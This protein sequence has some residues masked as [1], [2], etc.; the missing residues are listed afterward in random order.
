MISTCASHLPVAV[1]AAWDDLTL[2]D[3]EAMRKFYSRCHATG[4]R[5]I[6]VVDARRCNA[7]AAP[8]RR[9]L[10]DMTNAFEP[11]VRGRSIGT[12][13]ILDSAVLI[14]VLTALR[15]FIKGNSGEL[16]Y[17][18]SARE[19]VV[20]AEAQLKAEHLSVPVAGRA[21]VTRLD[22]AVDLGFVND[23]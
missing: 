14:G 19:A 16:R 2:D 10:A 22:G 21:L 8:I 11:E 15:W 18:P 1:V 20:W 23:G 4:L 9:A 7:P 17:F 6:S 12:A 3:V 13:V 5:F